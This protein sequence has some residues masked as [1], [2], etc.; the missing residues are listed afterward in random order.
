MYA[1]IIFACAAVL[2]VL[3]EIFKM[4][5]KFI[6]R[7]VI[8]VFLGMMLLFLVNYIGG[9][10]DYHIALNKVNAF[11]IGLLGVPGVFAIMVLKYL[12]I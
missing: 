6:S 2:F 11:I 3:G 1:W 10:F 12:N 5:R 7:V 8:N 9:Y 4:P